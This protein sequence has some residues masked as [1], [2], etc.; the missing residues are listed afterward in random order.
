MAIEDY[1]GVAFGMPDLDWG[2]DMTNVQFYGLVV[3]ALGNQVIVGSELRPGDPSYADVLNNGGDMQEY[4]DMSALKV[5][6]TNYL[7]S[8]H[9]DLIA[10]VESALSVVAPKSSLDWSAQN[11]ELRFVTAELYNAN[12]ANLK[13]AA[14]D[15]AIDAVVAMTDALA[16]DRVAF[17]AYVLSSGYTKSAVPAPKSTGF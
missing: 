6:A 9:P 7:R 12:I 11:D 16:K 14:A 2:S 5:L 1:R 3:R 17:E 10:N 15:K 13:G 8:K 4:P